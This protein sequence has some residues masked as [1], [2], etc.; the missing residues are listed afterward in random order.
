MV[1]QLFFKGIN[2]VGEYIPVRQYSVVEEVLP[3]TTV[4]DQLSDK[5]FSRSIGVL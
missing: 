4:F 2:A 5:A 3:F 1:V